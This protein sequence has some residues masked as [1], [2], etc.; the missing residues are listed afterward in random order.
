MQTLGKLIREVELDGSIFYIRGLTVGEYCDIAMRGLFKDSE[1]L[2]VEIAMSGI[3]GWENIFVE[4]EFGNPMLFEFREQNKESLDI[5]HLVYLGKKIYHELTILSD[6]EHNKFEAATRFLHFS[7]EPKNRSISETFDCDTCIKKGLA[8]TR[9]C[10]RFSVEE[11]ENMMADLQE[12]K[13]SNTGD[14]TRPQHDIKSKYK[15][16]RTKMYF[17][18]EE[19]SKKREKKPG[20]NLD[21]YTYPECPISY[22]DPWISILCGIL[23]HCAKSNVTFFS[24]GIVDQPY[25]YYRAER[26][27]S[28]ESSKI[29]SEEM[30]RIRKESDRKRS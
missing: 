4:D 2:W 10:G 28:S 8:R 26:V 11:I 17:A 15:S 18:S 27:V 22:I 12:S 5:E 19:E 3:M 21:K 1:R 23:Y 14:S 9:P 24:G 30:D 16:K 25:K 13:E 6:V 20:I 29:E 7:G